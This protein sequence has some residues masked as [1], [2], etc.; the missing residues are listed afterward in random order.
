MEGDVPAFPNARYV[1]GRQ[2]YDAWSDGARIQ[3]PGKT[4]SR[5]LAKPA[6][7]GAAC[8]GGDGPG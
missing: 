1:I 7:G 2:E 6:R 5:R 8:L 3:L 4:S